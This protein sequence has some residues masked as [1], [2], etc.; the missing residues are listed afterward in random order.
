MD[1]ICL[2]YSGI[3]Q[4]V[5][6]FDYIFALMT[7][8]GWRNLNSYYNVNIRTACAYIR[9]ENLTD[10]ESRRLIA[11]SEKNRYKLGYDISGLNIPKRFTYL[12]H[13]IS[14]VNFRRVIEQ[15]VTYNI[16]YATVNNY[17][18][19]INPKL[20]KTFNY[21]RKFKTKTEIKP[22]FKSIVT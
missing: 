1:L 9:L 21:D 2:K 7:K 16:A 3:P 17:R 11:I 15:G 13:K 12:N 6:E 5:E 22:K 19:T 20:I 18:V 4:W 10:E 14:K 8:Y